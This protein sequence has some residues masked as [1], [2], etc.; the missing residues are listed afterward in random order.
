MAIFILVI[1]LII[2]LL[3]FALEIFV[4]PGISIAGIGAAVTWIYSFYFAFTE[5]GV[6]AGILSIIIAAI[7]IVA[8][9][10][11]F[12]KSKTVDHLALKEILS[13][14]ENP[15]ERLGLK[16]GD[17]GIAV[18]KLS[19]IGQAIFSDA[20]VEVHSAEGFIDEQSPIQIIRIQNRTVYVGRKNA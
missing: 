5:F 12:M 6:L 15:I 3:L 14:P 11:W 16:V 20:L 1:L 13:T 7:S 18:T 17:C 8:C 19:L 9:I 4:L 10:V 2:S